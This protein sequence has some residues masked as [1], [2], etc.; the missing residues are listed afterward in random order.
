VQKEPNSNLY[1]I[2][3][4]HESNYTKGTFNAVQ[5]SG[6]GPKHSRAD[7]ANY[8]A[9]SSRGA[10]KTQLMKQPI[11]QSKNRPQPLF[12]KNTISS[13]G[14]QI[15][16]ANHQPGQMRASTNFT[17]MHQ[18][19]ANKGLG[20]QVSSENHK[21]AVSPAVNENKFSFDSQHNNLMMSAGQNLHSSGLA[22]QNM[23]NNHQFYS[24][25]RF[26]SPLLHKNNLIFPKKEQL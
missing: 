13:S 8:S 21:K 22:I 14:S 20:S 2:P 23:G 10:V 3:S 1:S 6:N 24:S 11:I 9:G 25:Q 7:S 16:Q 12:M 18:V 26:T 15:N 4:P 17:S 19:S 5:S